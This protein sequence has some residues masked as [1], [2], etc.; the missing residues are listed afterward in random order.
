MKILLI[1]ELGFS[2]SLLMQKMQ[3]AAGEKG[4]QDLEI[5]ATNID[6]LDK[7]ADDVDV[8]L[9]APQIKYLLSEVEEKVN[10]KA[11][12]EVLDSRDYGLGRGENI[13]NKVLEEEKK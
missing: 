4:V 7:Y 6:D 1:C 5:E 2:S 8:V 13:L 12:V 10:S 3:K 11:K 9:V